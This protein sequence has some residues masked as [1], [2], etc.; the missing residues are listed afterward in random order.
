[1]NYFMTVNHQY[2]DFEIKMHSFVIKLENNNF[3]RKEHINHEWVLPEDLTMLDWVPE[4]L[5]IIEKLMNQT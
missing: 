1:M 2:P 5:P 3:E 4:D